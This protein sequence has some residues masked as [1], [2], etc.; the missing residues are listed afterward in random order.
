MNW[1]RLPII[2]TILVAAAVATMIGLG[3]WQIRRA[4]WKSGLLA[5]YE[6]A[7]TMPEI[8]WPTVPIKDPLPLFRKATGNCLR[9]AD[10]RT[11]PGQNLSGEPGFLIVADCVTGAEGP[12]MAVEMGWTKDPAAGRGWGGGLV[13]GII[14][15]DRDQRMRLV[16]DKPL[17]G[18]GASAPPSTDSIPN[19]HLGYA[20]QWFLFAATALIIYAIAVRKKLQ[21]TAPDG[22]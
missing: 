11:R 15:P 17:Q 19:N 14:G 7:R 18:L 6:A 4:E 13:S 9:V 5:Q 8:G 16:V 21:G 1:K 3:L 22:G 12:G 20:I 2:P 10:Y